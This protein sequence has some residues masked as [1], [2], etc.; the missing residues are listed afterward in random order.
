M[1]VLHCKGNRLADCQLCCNCRYKLYMYITCT[2]C[3]N[4]KFEKSYWNM[5]K[6]STCN[7]N[8]LNLIKKNRLLASEYI[9]AIFENVR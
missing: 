3:I 1:S 2:N 7:K 9:C 6:D 4:D 8:Q 5:K